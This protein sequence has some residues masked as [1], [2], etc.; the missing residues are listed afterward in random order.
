MEF[1]LY[2]LTGVI[3][4]FLAGLLGVGGGL[5]IVPALFAIYMGLGY[6]SNH[7][8]HIALGTSLATIIFTSISSV[9]AHHKR[10]AVMWSAVIRLSPGIV[11]GAWLGALIA[12]YLP[13]DNLR[14]IFGVFELYVATQMLFSLRPSAHR[15]LPGNA[16]MFAAGGGIGVVSSIVGIGG[17]TLTVPFLSWCNTVM[18][19]AVAT[20]AACGLPIAVAGAMGFVVAGWGIEGLPT[21]S[22]GYVHLPSML[23]VAVA[24]VMIAPL[25]AK[26]AHQ[27]PAKTL[28]RIFAVVLYLIAGYMLLG[29]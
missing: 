19:K 10:G 23:G 24:S 8:M 2:A 12:K 21:Q 17:G 3:A 5:V 28:K 9:W 7:L 18:Q 13:S 22:L 15:S 25:G 26:L 20:S 11:I 6:E 4:G 16:G 14:W 1:L 27:L 29:G